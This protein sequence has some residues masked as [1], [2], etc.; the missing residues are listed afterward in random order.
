MTNA[1][2]IYARFEVLEERLAHCYFILHERFIADPQL[3]RFWAEAALDELQHSSI[4]RF[5]REHRLFADTDVDVPT[6]DRIDDLIDSVRA[7][8]KN[9]GVT[10]QEAFYASLLMES[11]ELDE[12]FEKLTG[13]LAADHRVLYQAIRASMRLHHDKFAD[14]AAE[15]LKDRACVDAFR[16]LNR[17]ELVQAK[18]NKP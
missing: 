8:V 11:S 4:L 2:A 3:A 7:I 10:I 16:N 5:C 6:A 13:A 12:A 1:N 14:G 9:P 15:F 17:M 18:G